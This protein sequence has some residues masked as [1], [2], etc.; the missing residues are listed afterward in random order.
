MAFPPLPDEA[1]IEEI[2]ADPQPGDRFHEYY[3]FWCYVVARDGE[4]VTIMHASAPCS[5]PEDGTVETM[6][7]EELRAKFR[8]ETMQRYY[9]GGAGRGHNVDGWI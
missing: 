2:M 4:R 3:A 7:V 6:T 5:F 1:E 9:V 8:Y